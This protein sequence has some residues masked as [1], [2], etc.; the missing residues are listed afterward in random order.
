[1]TWDIQGAQ[2]VTNETLVENFA[3]EELIA[4]AIATKAGLD[5]V[6]LPT[7]SVADRLLT[8]QGIGA[9]WLEVKSRTT[10]CREFATY[11]LSSSKLEGLCDLAQLTQLPA[12]IAVAF[13]CGCVKTISARSPMWSYN[14]R[15][16]E[17][18]IERLTT[19]KIGS[20]C[21]R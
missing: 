21:V 6:S 13:G 18:D 11:R 20:N 16:A 8:N 12:L 15:G 4:Q 3:T 9:V 2:R 14:K 7:F 19:I 5:L 10:P 1:M 17:I